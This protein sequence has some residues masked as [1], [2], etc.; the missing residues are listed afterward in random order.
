MNIKLERERG[1]IPNKV[2]YQINS[3]SPTENYIEQKQKII[4][5]YKERQKKKIEQEQEKKKIE[6][7][8]EKELDKEIKKQLDKLFSNI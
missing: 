2:Y 5:F 8:L 4:K 1:H 3:N 6:I 7:I